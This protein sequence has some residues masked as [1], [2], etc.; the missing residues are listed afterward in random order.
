MVIRT[1]GGEIEIM[2]TK[3]PY[4]EVLMGKIRERRIMVWH[5]DRKYM[6]YRNAEGSPAVIAKKQLEGRERSPLFY[7]SF[8][9]FL[10]CV[11]SYGER[12]MA[13]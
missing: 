12:N 8:L 7:N 11:Q 13:S 4:V 10:S 6:F 9:S 2:C 3:E 1:K 5:D